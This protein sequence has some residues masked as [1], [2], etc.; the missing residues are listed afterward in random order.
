MEP[1]NDTQQAEQTD[2]PA[3]F[4]ALYAEMMRCVQFMRPELTLQ[5]VDEVIKRTL[6]NNDKDTTHRLEFNALLEYHADDV[7][8]YGDDEYAFPKK[9]IE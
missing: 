9:V 1:I 6:N 2:E 7:L 3:D 5:Q 8:G 4:M